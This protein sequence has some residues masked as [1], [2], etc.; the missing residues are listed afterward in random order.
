MSI[1]IKK[2]SD[3]YDAVNIRLTPKMKYALTLAA[4]LKDKSQASYVVE[5]VLEKLQAKDSGL[6]ITLPNGNRENYL[7][8]LVW[9]ELKYRRITNMGI[10]APH[11]LDGMELLIWTVIEETPSFWKN[12]KP[13]FSLIRDNW[14][15]IKSDAI[16]LDESNI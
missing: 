2:K 9:H 8:D 6:M 15:K 10:Y 13:E 1:T 4:K 7:P 3:K 12:G 14:Q 11:L 5:C 16:K